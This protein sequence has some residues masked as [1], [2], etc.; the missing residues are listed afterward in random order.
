[1]LAP[2]ADRLNNFANSANASYGRAPRSY[3][4]D[5]PPHVPVP[6]FTYD[7]LYFAISN[8]AKALDAAYKF[9]KGKRGV[10]MRQLLEAVNAGR[11]PAPQRRT[12][13]QVL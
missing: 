12:N 8:D 13:E 9:F 1:M 11:Y 5:L 7:E 4:T 10:D 3:N 2:E 6:P